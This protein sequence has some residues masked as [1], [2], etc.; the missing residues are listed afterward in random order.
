MDLLHLESVAV[1][2]YE[3]LGLDPS[4][5]VDTCKL[6]RLRFRGRGDSTPIVTRPPSLL[7]AR[8]GAVW[9]K[10]ETPFIAV[11]KTVPIEIVQ[12][13]VGHE[14][15]HLLLG[16]KHDS[17]PDLEAACDYL[18]ACLMA[19]RPAVLALH[20]AHGWKL[21]EIAEEVCATQT[22]AALR[23]GEALGIPLAAISPV[24]VRVR[25]PEEWA[26]PSEP[27]IRQLAR[28]QR[29][30]L[31]KVAITDQRARCAII[32]EDLTG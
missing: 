6:A 29:P 19:P 24:A 28:R 5:P 10:G 31:K 9:W 7:G 15:G 27:E 13:V 22:W 20:R 21:R 11:R 12:H 2:T 1:E 8:P 23:L 14:M 16:R 4:E 25:G 32:C 3:R 18:G 30:G 17:D 26:W